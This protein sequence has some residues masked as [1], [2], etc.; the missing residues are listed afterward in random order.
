MKNI[1][2][3]LIISFCVTSNLFSQVDFGVIAGP[4]FSNVRFIQDS[5][6]NDTGSNESQ[7]YRLGIHAGFLLN[8][9]INNHFSI[10]SNILYN[11]KGYDYTDQFTNENGKVSLHYITLPTAMG[12][13]IFP[14]TT[15]QLGPEI[16]YLA[17]SRIKQGNI[18]QDAS[19]FYTKKFNLSALAGIN[20]ALTDHLELGIRYLYGITRMNRETF[21]T[22]TDENG[23][24]LGVINLKTKNRAFQLSMRYRI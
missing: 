2:S 4:N 14:N 9:K 23:A 10:E 1:I 19:D 20:Y 5:D 18:N 24:A 7:D 3:F 16:G 11:L 22:I 12:Y 15:L 13:Q 17:S 21:V 8:I 6:F